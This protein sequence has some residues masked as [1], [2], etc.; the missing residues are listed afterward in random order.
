MKDSKT[1]KQILAMLDDKKRKIFLIKLWLVFAFTFLALAASS[2][3]DSPLSVMPRAACCFV[4]GCLYFYIV[5][6]RTYPK[7]EKYFDIE[8]LK[9]DAQ[10]EN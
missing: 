6:I 3:W 9:K 7:I 2:Q 4:M 1:A 8:A 5:A 10:M